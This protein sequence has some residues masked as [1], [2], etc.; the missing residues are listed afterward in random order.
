MNEQKLISEWLDLSGNKHDNVPVFPENKKFQ[1]ALSLVL[2]ELLEAAEAGTYEQTYEFF[3]NVRRTIDKHMDKLLTSPKK[4]SGSVDELRDACAD[5]RVVMGNLIHFAGLRDKFDEDFK[6]VMDSNFSKYCKTEDEAKES[7]R[8][9]SKGT[10]PAK[11]GEKIE[12]YYE[13]VGE[14]FIIKNKETNKILKSV[15]FREPNFKK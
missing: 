1:L 15:N 14:Y 13:K 12:T 2:E 6:E 9:Y 5:L 8:L 3:N 10:H 11:M 4:E 7:V